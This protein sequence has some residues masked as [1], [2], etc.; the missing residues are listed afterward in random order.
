MILEPRCITYH[1]VQ[2]LVSK[3]W[4]CQASS[5]IV[6]F[7]V[8]GGPCV[9]YIDTL[10]AR[11]LTCTPKIIHNIHVAFL[12]SDERDIGGCQF[13]TIFDL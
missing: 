13:E 11:M 12:G 2:N 3:L 1:G 10:T 5:D 7:I 8:V 9:P 4:V 6:Q